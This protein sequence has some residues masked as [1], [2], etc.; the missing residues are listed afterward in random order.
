M[1]KRILAMLLLAALCMSLLAACGGSDV[2]DSQKAQQIAL[3]HAGL[4]ADEVSNI[5]THI[6]EHE[7]VPCFNIHLTCAD[8]E[9]SYIISANGGEIL[10]HG[11]GGHG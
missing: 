1:K 5:H 11:E 9:F 10:E 6:I 3:D 2:I 7:G 4:T 8:G